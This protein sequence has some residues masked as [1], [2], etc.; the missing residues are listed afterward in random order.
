MKKHITHFGLIL[1]VL[2]LLSGCAQELEP[3]AEPVVAPGP[4]RHIALDGQAN[5]RDLGGYETADSR[6]V[7]WGEAPSARESTAR[8]SSPSR[9]GT[10]PNV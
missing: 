9:Q 8:P 5:F 4:E 10:S 7:R 3:V 2:V 1:P 6:V